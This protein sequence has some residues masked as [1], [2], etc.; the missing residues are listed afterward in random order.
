MELAVQGLSLR[1]EVVEG[2]FFKF[3]PDADIYVLKRVIHD[4]DDEQS[5]RILTNCARG[6]RKAGRI[7][8]LEQVLPDDGRPSQTA[9]ADLNMLVLLPGCERT[10]P[11]FDSLLTL[12][13]FRLQRITATAS[14]LHI[15]EASL[16]RSG[17]C[18]P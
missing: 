3:V 6:L 9:L 17:Y 4:W 18:A 1:C 8:L 5:V 15:I 10:A 14:S 16:V 11:Q 13:G 12:A 2:D 7:V